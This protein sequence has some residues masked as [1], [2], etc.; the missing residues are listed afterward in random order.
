[1]KNY[2]WTKTAVST[3]VYTISWYDGSTLLCQ[4]QTK[5][6]GPEVEVEIALGLAAEQLRKENPALFPEEVE[7]KEE[8]MTMSS[9]EEIYG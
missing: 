6:I 2:H 8:P 4:T 7:E 3:N 9:E 5:I 1:M